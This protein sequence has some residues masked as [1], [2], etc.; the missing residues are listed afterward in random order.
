[1]G[2]KR[3]FKYFTSVRI[4]I[5]IILAVCLLSVVI[6]EFVFSN[7]PELFTGGTNITK[8]FERL[9]LSY[10]SS[11]VFFFLWFT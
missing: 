3:W 7:I 8:I 5:N 2:L 1:M 11:Y 9:C 6:I 4:E 10:I